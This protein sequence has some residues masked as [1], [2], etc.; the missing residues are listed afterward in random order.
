[1]TNI[2][3][4]QLF[5]VLVEVCVADSGDLND[6]LSGAPVALGGAVE[7]LSVELSRPNRIEELVVDAHER[8]LAARQNRVVV[9]HLLSLAGYVD[10]SEQTQHLEAQHSTDHQ[11]IQ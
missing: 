5:E 2:V 3:V 1:L 4:E 6:V 10:C 8:Q 9:G 7:L 11:Q